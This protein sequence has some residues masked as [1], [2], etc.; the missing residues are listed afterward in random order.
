VRSEVGTRVDNFFLNADWAD[1]ADLGGSEKRKGISCLVFLFRVVSVLRGGSWG[2][3]FG[4]LLVLLVLL[5]P[6]IP[7]FGF[8][9]CC[10]GRIKTEPRNKRNKRNKK[11]PNH[12]TH[13]S[14]KE[15]TKQEILGFQIR[16]NP[17][18]PPNPRSKKP[19]GGSSQRFMRTYY[20]IAID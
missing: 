16:L 9:A 3:R 11:K 5:V 14:H 2:S 7:W 6:L 12:E 17:P 10:T 13:G 19:A 8:V 18:D 15:D 4:F 1:Q 20:S